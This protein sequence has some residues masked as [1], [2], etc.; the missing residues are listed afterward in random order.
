[1]SSY[2]VL[3]DA[4]FTKHS[5][6]QI[7]KNINYSFLDRIPLEH[8]GIKKWN[9]MLIL[10]ESQDLNEVRTFIEMIV[11]GGFPEDHILVWDVEPVNFTVSKTLTMSVVVDLNP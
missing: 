9:G 10:K 11:K 5:F 4:E 8:Y 3:A 2:F 1:M 6:E 7:L